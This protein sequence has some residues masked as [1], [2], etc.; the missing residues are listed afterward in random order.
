MAQIV[1]IKSI[2]HLTHDVLQII[3]EKPEGLAFEPGQ[4]AD[5]AVNRP[6]WEEKMHA[7]TFTSLPE[8]DHIEFTIKTYPEHK[9]VTNEMLTLKAG[10]ELLFGGVFGKI[11]YKGK[12]VFIAGGSGI[13]P[14]LAI[15]K[16]LVKT[17]KLEGNQLIFANK[18]KADIILE[19]YFRKILGGQYVNILS[20][21]KIDAY[22]QGYIDAEL[23]EKYVDADVKYYYLCG[24]KP[25]MKAV[26]ALLA[27]RGIADES[28]IKERF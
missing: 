23:L 9:G 4:A 17:N 7:F 21:E 6:G 26:E 11:R 5:I 20:D 19:D 25:M 28:I 14:F 12:G 24:P 10:D 16:Q 15:I 27:T 1:K 2:M 13:T 18:T 8:E 22:E 3:A